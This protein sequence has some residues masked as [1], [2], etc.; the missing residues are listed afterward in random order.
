MYPQRVGRQK[1]LLEIQF[2]FNDGRRGG[3]MNRGRGRPR[4]DRS[5]QLDGAGTG[6]YRP[7][8][9]VVAAATVANPMNVSSVWA[10]VPLLV[11]V[12]RLS[13]NVE[14]VFHVSHGRTM[15]VVIVAQHL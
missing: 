12:V 11:N 9:V 6:G 3:G 8:V 2:H 15:S 4:G 10:A 14:S 1:H 5:D 13:V 7:K